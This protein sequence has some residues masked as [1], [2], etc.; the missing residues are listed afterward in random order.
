MSM[1]SSKQ[2]VMPIGPDLSDVSR[3]GGKAAGLARLHRCGLNVP[4]GLCVMVTA[5]DHH[6]DVAGVGT[7][8]RCAS[9]P[10]TLMPADV[11]R[12]ILAAP[13]DPDLEQE[14]VDAFADLD[15]GL[16]AVRSSGLEEDGVT[17]AHAGMYDT[18]L[19]VRGVPAC[20]DAIKRCWASAWSDRAVSY[21]TARDV[22]LTGM[23]VVVQAMVQADAA[24]VL[25]SVDPVSG[26]DDR[27]IIEAAPGLGEDLVAGRITPDRWRVTKKDGVVIESP[28]GVGT[29]CVRAVVIQ[30]LVDAARRLEAHQGG[31]V[32][33]EWAVQGPRVYYV[34]SRMV[35]T[36]TSGISNSQLPPSVTISVL[37]DEDDEPAAVEETAFS[38]GTDVESTPTPD[39]NRPQLRRAGPHDQPGGGDGTAAAP[40]EAAAQPDPIDDVEPFEDCAPTAVDEVFSTPSPVPVDQDVRQ[41]WSNVNAG[42]VLPDVVSPLTWSLL[43][44]V[45]RTLRRV[46]KR[47]GID[48]GSLPLMGRV[49]GRVYFNV[50]TLVGA[51]ERAQILGRAGINRALGGMGIDDDHGGVL[52][53][54]PED[55]PRVNTS[56]GVMLSHLPMAMLWSLRHHPWSAP[57]L[58][59]RLERRRRTAESS[60]K[61]IRESAET[62]DLFNAVIDGL[63]IDEAIVAVPGCGG[64]FY[65]LLDMTCTHLLGGRTS[66]AALLCGQGGVA[67]ADAGLA[68]WKLA[69]AGRADAA[70]EHAL[71]NSGSFADLSATLSSFDSGR[72]FL[73][74]WS[75]FC[76]EHGHHACGE[77]ELATPRWAETPNY[78]LNLVRNYI[79]MMPEHDAL[80]AYRERA[81]ETDARVA[82]CRSQLRRV[83]KIGLFMGVLKGARAGAAARENIKNEAVRHVALARRIALTLGHHL[84][85]AGLIDEADHVFMFYR[86]ELHAIVNERYRGCPRH[87]ATQRQ[88]E[89]A[90]QSTMR[91]PAVVRGAYHGQSTVRV[92]EATLLMTGLAVSAGRARGR[93]RVINHATADQHVRSGEVLVAPFTDPGWTPYFLPAVGIVTDLGGLLSH[94]SIIAR[95]YGIPA[96]VNVHH[97][98]QVIKTGQMIEVDGDLGV[99]RVLGPSA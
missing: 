34:Q 42:E 54:P 7:G 4:R 78:L 98:T 90:A 13:I 81:R 52:D 53:L 94:G 57:R 31:A 5:F 91:P 65:M 68:L 33:I 21:R 84:V 51:C 35:T 95:E 56:P 97:A 73:D 99:V 58:L 66:A 75:A 2:C 88:A 62:L 14:I 79:T 83:A 92:P 12:R 18:M 41:V 46:L 15:L 55:I 64:A 37:A 32:D 59:A 89:C 24:G 20:L 44:A 23:A 30:E 82:T 39:H 86:S 26:R 49:A 85:A 6:V 80:T 93:A 9:Q 38:T 11:R 47:L 63:F 96:V 10:D 60:L 61:T 74:R 29:P 1:S 45:D 76:A 28:T 27:A 17:S 48:I 87:I 67:S 16:V 43:E 71:L 40:D 8:R 69:A 25:F 36:V 72:V 3:F 77:V 19:N 22:P 50:N 70:V